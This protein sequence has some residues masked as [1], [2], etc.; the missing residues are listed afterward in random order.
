M[1][2]GWMVS[3]YAKA[4]PKPS[5]SADL[6]HGRSQKC[7]TFDNEPLAGEKEDF[8]IQFVEAYGF[9]M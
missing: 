7:D 3:C 5:F 1:V 8:I 9:R 2:F 4:R 6:N